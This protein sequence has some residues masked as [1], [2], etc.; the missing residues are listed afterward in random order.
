[1]RYIAARTFKRYAG[2][3][4]RMNSIRV[5]SRERTYHRV[6][7]EGEAI[8]SRTEITEGSERSTDW[9]VGVN[10]EPIF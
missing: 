6:R 8:A 1:M 2:A 5:T 3:Q 7:F 9:V 4:I 10:L